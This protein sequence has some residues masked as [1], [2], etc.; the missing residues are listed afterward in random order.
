LGADDKTTAWELWVCREGASE[1]EDKEIK[2]AC[3]A[4]ALTSE[5]EKNVGGSLLLFCFLVER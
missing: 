4:V 5:G 2:E 3:S 1:A